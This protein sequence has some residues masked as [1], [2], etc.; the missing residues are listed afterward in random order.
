MEKTKNETHLLKIGED[1]M[2]GKTGVDYQFEIG[3]VYVPGLDPRSGELK[4]NV[5]NSL[6]LP[7]KM[8]ITKNDDKFTKKVLKSY[9]D[10]EKT[11]G[12]LLAGTKGTGKTVMAK[13]IAKLSELPILTIDNN[14]HPSY[15]KE[16]FSKLENTPMCILFDEFDKFGERYDSDQI[17]RVLDGVS[18]SG[19][20]LLVF[21]CNE[22]DE[23]NEYMLDRCS[24]IRYYREFDEMSPSMIS[25]ILNDRLN[26]KSETKPLTDF[27]VKN[28]GL[29]SFDNVASFADEVNEYPDATFEELFE[30]MNIST[31]D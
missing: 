28:F 25:E 20:H 6:T 7:E 4:L 13:Q 11:L 26:D 24:R 2:F 19:K 21:T 27:I 23:V 15:L 16:L 14:L 17:L 22:T 9:E 18:S 29:V 12:V 10:A 3:T 30:D 8:Y 5:G 31:K 1:I